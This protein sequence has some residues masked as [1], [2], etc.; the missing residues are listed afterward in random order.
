MICRHRNELV[1]LFS[2]TPP[3]NPPSPRYTHTR[4][5]EYHLE[6][7]NRKIIF[8]S[9]SPRAPP[10][11]SPLTKILIRRKEKKNTAKNAN[12]IELQNYDARPSFYLILFSTI[13]LLQLFLLDFMKNLSTFRIIL[14]KIG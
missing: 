4:P 10:P 5:T 2:P 8:A 11:P 13:F 6:E 1:K 12:N 14:N 7:R 9:S 3:Q